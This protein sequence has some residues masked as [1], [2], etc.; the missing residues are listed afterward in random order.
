[1]TCISLSPGCKLLLPNPSIFALSSSAFASMVIS[2]T[3]FGKFRWYSDFVLSK[4]GLKVPSL[5]FRDD[6]SLLLD[7]FGTDVPVL[8][9]GLL[10]LGF[11]FVE[12][13]DCIDWHLHRKNQLQVLLLQ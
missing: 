11:V 4:F 5:T 13:L 1:M 9:F 8:G 2:F 12:L 6:K 3:S 7:F 10:V